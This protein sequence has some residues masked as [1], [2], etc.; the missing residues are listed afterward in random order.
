[1]RRSIHIVLSAFVFASLVCGC[2][3]TASRIKKNSKAFDSFPEEV[4]E[5]VRKGKVEIGYTKDMAYIALGDPDN[6]YIRTTSDGDREVWAYISVYATKQ[7]QLVK[8]PFR[9][10]T[11]DGE[12]RTVY[13]ESI[14]VDVD[15]IREYENLRLEFDDGG[16]VA[17]IDRLER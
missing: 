14:W 9:T 3:T 2:G 8:G 7:R 1:M 13:G 6:R 10:R 15:Q 12:Y 17:A 4:Q 16:V 5:K 11:T